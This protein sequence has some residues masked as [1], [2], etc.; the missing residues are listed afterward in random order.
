MDNY[1]YDDQRDK[2]ETSLQDYLAII[3]KRKWTI[4][5]FALVVVATVTIG[6]FLK[7]PTYTAK[8]TLLVEKEPN[9]LSF[10]DIFQI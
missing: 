1:G 4:I 8:G 9:I 3:L 2:V 10:Q 6:S 5:S 7:K